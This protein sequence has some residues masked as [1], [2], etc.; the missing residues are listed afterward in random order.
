MKYTLN[1][2]RNDDDGDEWWVL[3]HTEDGDHLTVIIV[4]DDSDDDSGQ[5]I[6][7]YIEKT[8]RGTIGYTDDEIARIEGHEAISTSPNAKTFEKMA[9]V[10]RRLFVLVNLGRYIS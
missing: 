6:L 4:Q 2:E 1:I 9:T 3:N 5:P 8:V 10:A 7:Y